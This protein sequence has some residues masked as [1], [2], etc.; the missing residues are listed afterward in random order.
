M[1][2]DARLPVQH[3]LNK[4]VIGFKEEQGHLVARIGQRHRYVHYVRM[5]QPARVENGYICC[6]R[7][8]LPLNF[9]RQL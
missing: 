3:V 4:A 1:D 6:A 9:S 7:H 8:L 5:Q 2:R